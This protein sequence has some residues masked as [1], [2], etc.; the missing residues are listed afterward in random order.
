MFKN[1]V[2]PYVFLDLG[3]VQRVPLLQ[4]AQSDSGPT[5]APTFRDGLPND[6]RR[7]C[8]GFVAVDAVGGDLA[9]ATV[10]SSKFRVEVAA[11]DAAAF[12]AVNRAAGIPGQRLDA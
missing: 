10:L 6:T 12:S 4:L 2:R 11:P 7:L 3:G 9:S 8:S 1:L 5:H